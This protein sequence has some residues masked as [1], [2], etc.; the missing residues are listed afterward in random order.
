MKNDSELE[1][2]MS[3]IL[4]LKKKVNDLESVVSN[5]SRGIRAIISDLS[6]EE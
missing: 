5:Q 2:L 3:E 6:E 4:S 1:Y